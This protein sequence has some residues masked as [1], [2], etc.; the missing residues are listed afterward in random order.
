MQYCP[1]II[2]QAPCLTAL[3]QQQWAHSSSAQLGHSKP[4]PHSSWS[5]INY[6]RF[7][8]GSSSS[9]CLFCSCSLWCSPASPC[10]S[11]SSDYCYTLRCSNRFPACPLHA[12]LFTQRSLYCHSNLC[13]V[14]SYIYVIQVHGVILIDSYDND[15]ARSSFAR[16]LKT[17]TVCCRMLSRTALVGLVSPCIYFS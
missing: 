8:Q 12:A 6:L 16:Q 13:L 10:A 4:A 7:S 17:L 9:L 14:C 2:T 11:S 3:S 15:A 1:Y 5:I